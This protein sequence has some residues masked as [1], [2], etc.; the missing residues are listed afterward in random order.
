MNSI[1]VPTWTTVNGM[2][3]HGLLTNA[4]QMATGA[5]TKV[6]AME[7]LS[8]EPMDAGRSPP[9]ARR[10]LQGTELSTGPRQPRVTI[11][12][13]RNS[14]FQ[15]NLRK[16]KAY[17]EEIKR[18]GAL[19]QERQVRIFRGLHNLS[20]SR[21]AGSTLGASVVA[22]SARSITTSGRSRCR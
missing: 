18:S 11:K 12:D 20:D 1:L 5:P 7:S 4:I 6:P 15:W 8:T 10:E 17:F 13:V 9:Q 19:A 21:A 22:F 14:F 16:S 3:N 2:R